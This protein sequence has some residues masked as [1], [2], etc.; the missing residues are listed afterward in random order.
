M[1]FVSIITLDVSYIEYKFYML[2]YFFIKGS[3]RT[4][5]PVQTTVHS[6]LYQPA[7]LHVDIQAFPKPTGDNVTWMKCSQSSC[8]ILETDGNILQHTYD[9]DFSLIFKNVTHNDFGRYIVHIDNGVGEGT[10][11]DFQ[12][13]QTG[14]VTVSYNGFISFIK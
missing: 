7:V 14:I 2:L 10:D 1:H 12:L 13:T 11:V 9:L 8:Q 3:P 6:V 4:S 5:S